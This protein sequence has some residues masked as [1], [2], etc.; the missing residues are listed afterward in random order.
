M[1]QPGGSTT[2][3]TYLYVIQE[4]SR[5]PKNSFLLLSHWMSHP[6]TTLGLN[7][8]LVT[9]TSRRLAS[10]CVSHSEDEWPVAF[11][12]GASLQGCASKVNALQN[13]YFFHPLLCTLDNGVDSGCVTGMFLGQPRSRGVDVALM[14]HYRYTIMGEAEQG[15]ELIAEGSAG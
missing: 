10:L 7:F 1:T 3:N 4:L 2:E 5:I 15:L 6:V 13:A 14:L 12:L 9:V 11:S 8:S